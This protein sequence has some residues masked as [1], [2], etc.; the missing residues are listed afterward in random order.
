MIQTLAT[1]GVVLAILV[2]WYLRRKRKIG[3]GGK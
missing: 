1:S 2:W 3:A